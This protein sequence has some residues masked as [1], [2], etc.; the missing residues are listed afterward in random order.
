VFEEKHPLLVRGR[1]SDVHDYGDSRVLKL[2]RHGF[3]AEWVA[4][5]RQNLLLAQANG[6]PVPRCYEQIEEQQRHGLVLERLTG[7]TLLQ[8]LMGEPRQLDDLARAFAE[9]HARI[10]EVT[11]DVLPSVK[12]RLGEEIQRVGSLPE[13]AKQAVLAG[14]E[15]LPD[16][17]ALCHG[18]FQPENVLF[19]DQGPVIIDWLDAR[20]GDPAADVAR[21]VLLLRHAAMPKGMH[22]SQRRALE[23][24]REQFFKIY[25]SQYRQRRPLSL[26]RME[27][28]LLPVAVAR[29]VET[30][31]PAEHA[32]LRNM[33]MHMLAARGS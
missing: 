1:N 12:E 16:G 29:L 5:E 21:T 30:V 25:I 10:H 14:L 8:M 9:L 23:G 31:P 28:W 24:R 17:Y 4:N 13:S 19:T 26:E 2:Y 32:R 33:V 11:T 3:P 7:R 15:A 18:D 27:A 6:L 22:L 20:R